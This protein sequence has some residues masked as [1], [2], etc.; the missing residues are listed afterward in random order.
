MRD[1]RVVGGRRNKQHVNWLLKHGTL[2]NVKERS[3]GDESR[4]ERH[5]RLFRGV[6]VAGQMSLQQIRV[7]LQRLRQA[8]C[9]HSL[10]HSWNRRQLGRKEP[11]QKYQLNTFPAS[12]CKPGK[13]LASQR[14]AIGHSQPEGNPTDGRDTSE[15]PLLIMRRRKAQP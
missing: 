8:A 5:K 11:I 1:R 12:E 3:I 6:G 10:G 14:L 2:R 4:V 15:S 9:E 7:L 13:S